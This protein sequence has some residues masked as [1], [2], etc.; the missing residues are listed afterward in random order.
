M[1]TE[2]TPPS[3]VEREMA[4]FRK[5]RADPKTEAQTS[6]DVAAARL[7]EDPSIRSALAVPPTP[8]RSHPLSASASI[9]T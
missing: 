5:A 2:S 9:R 3:R 1:S 4:A 7:L 8:D 6:L